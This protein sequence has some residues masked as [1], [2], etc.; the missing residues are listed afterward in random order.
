MDVQPEIVG[1]F[2]GPGL[3]ERL[4]HAAVAGR[5]AGVLVIYVKVGFRAGHPESV[6]A[7]GCSRRSRRREHSSRGRSR[8]LHPALAP[9]SG[10]LV[11]TKRRVSAFAG[12]DLDVVLRPVESM[13]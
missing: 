4:A 12:S 5:A 7:T 8:E 13:L 9:Q 11:L 6:R 10:D 3:T 2:G 1:R